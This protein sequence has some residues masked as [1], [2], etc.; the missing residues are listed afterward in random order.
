[1]QKDAKKKQGKDD[2][3]SLFQNGVIF[4]YYHKYML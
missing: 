4:T 1:M 2:T 3:E